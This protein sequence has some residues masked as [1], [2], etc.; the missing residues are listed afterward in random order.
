MNDKDDSGW[1]GLT[2]AIVN[3]FKEVV[4]LILLHSVKL[5]SKTVEI[6]NQAKEKMEIK[7]EGPNDTIFE[8]PLADVF[9]KP[10]NPITFGK[11]SSLHWAAY[12]GNT[13]ISSL[14]I[15]NGEQKPIVMALEI[16]MY[17]NTAL[18]QAAASNNYDVTCIN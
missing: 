18:H 5:S 15:K 4:K 3:G 1:I 17:G 6:L 12:K 14:L 9:K 7:D 16:D 11:Y 8:Q 2:W 10:I 13:I